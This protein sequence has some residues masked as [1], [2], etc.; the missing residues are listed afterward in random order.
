MPGAPP[1]L[2]TG[3][4]AGCRGRPLRCADRY[5]RQADGADG[6]ARPKT[7]PPSYRRCPGGVRVVPL[8][9]AGRPW[10]RLQ[11][12]SDGALL[13]C[14]G[15]RVVVATIRARLPPARLGRRLLG[16]AAPGQFDGE[17]DTSGSGR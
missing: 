2:L 14:Y 12:G 4:A 9:C 5:A 11:V 10:R 15:R 6:P 8:T 16:C 17:A 1:F 13:G 7:G 3:S